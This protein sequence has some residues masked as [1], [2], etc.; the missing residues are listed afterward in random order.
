M[1]LAY[2]ALDQQDLL[3]HPD[4]NTVDYSYA[5]CGCAGIYSVTVRDERCRY[6]KTTSPIAVNFLKQ[7]FDEHVSSV[8]SSQT[9]GSI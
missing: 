9:Q 6:R 7:G 2:D 5:G 4:G 8:R 3:T 1:Q